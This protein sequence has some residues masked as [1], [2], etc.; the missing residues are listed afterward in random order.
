VQF[1]SAVF[2]S[3]CASPGDA[4]SGNGSCF[5]LYILTQDGAAYRI[6]LPPPEKTNTK[7]GQKSVLSHLGRGNISSVPL[8]EELLTKVQSPTSLASSASGLLVGGAN[9]GVLC[10]PSYTFARVDLESVRV[11][12]VEGVTVLKDPILQRLWSGLVNLGQRAK[13]LVQGTKPNPV[14]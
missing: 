3:V 12:P 7:A 6:D 11:G 10:V 1:P 5:H 14:R 8:H 2:P 13:S 4:P 9:G